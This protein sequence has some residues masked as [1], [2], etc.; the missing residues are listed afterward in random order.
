MAEGRDWT[1]SQFEACPDCGFDAPAIDDTDIPRALT[2]QAAAWG[3][4]LASAPI[5]DLRRWPEPG[6]WSPLEYACHTRDV[7]GVFEE[8]VRQTAAR[9]D[10]QLG[11][12]DHEAAVTDEAYNTQE[13]VLVAEAM[14]E[15]ARRFA[16]TL[17]ELEIEAWDLSAE[18]RPG[19]YF[20]VRGM[21]RFVLHELAHHRH[22]A[23]RLVYG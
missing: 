19:E 1:R 9:S 5:A 13:P 14:A 20:T 7:V 16:S 21:A 11:W 12:W 18:R 4:F 2:D 3:A 10:Q 23:N 15:N 17:G 6:V 8:R 22:D